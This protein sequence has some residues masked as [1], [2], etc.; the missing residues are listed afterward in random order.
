MIH[1]ENSCGTFSFCNSCDKA[2]NCCTGKTVDMPLVTEQEAINIARDMEINMDNFCTPVNGGIFEIKRQDTNECYFYH[3]GKCSIYENRPIDC[4]L[5][6]FDLKISKKTNHLNLVKYD[7]V[8]PSLP[9]KMEREASQA[10]NLVNSL[11]KQKRFFANSNSPLLDKQSY[12]KIKII[13][14]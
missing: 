13:E 14:D 9:E 1:N 4:K 2:S 3:K 6:P 8:C 7:S 10:E 5:F 11:G 12:I